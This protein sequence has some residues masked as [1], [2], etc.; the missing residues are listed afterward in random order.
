MLDERDAETLAEVERRL[1]KVHRPDGG[2]EGPG[3]ICV[4]CTT[5]FGTPVED[6]IPFPCSAVRIVRGMAEAGEPDA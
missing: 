1:M 4:E 2:I 5:D 6:A 3:A